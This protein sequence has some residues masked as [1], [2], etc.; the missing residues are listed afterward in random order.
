MV[1]SDCLLLARKFS[2]S[3]TLHSSNILK[4][5]HD[6]ISSLEYVYNHMLPAMVAQCMITARLHH[7][8]NVMDV[9]R[10]PVGLKQR[11][12]QVH[13]IIIS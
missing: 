7:V 12:H 6:S 1:D 9:T 5:G 2:T 10:N 8:V 4:K 11:G 13:D 3:R